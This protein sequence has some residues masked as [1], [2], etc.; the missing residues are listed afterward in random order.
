MWNKCKTC[1]KGNK[2]LVDK[3]LPRFCLVKFSQC[4]SNL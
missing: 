1:E 4:D 3:I 2:G